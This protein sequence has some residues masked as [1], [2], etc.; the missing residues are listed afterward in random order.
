M[1]A[2]TTPGY[3]PDSNNGEHVAPVVPLRA[4][5]AHTEIGPDEAPAAAAT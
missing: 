5:D 4:A 3:G 2:D 1:S